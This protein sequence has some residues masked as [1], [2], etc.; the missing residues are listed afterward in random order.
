MIGTFRNQRDR[1]KKPAIDFPSLDFPLMEVD[2]FVQEFVKKYTYIY[3][4]FILI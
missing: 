1:T 2:K 3:I 4:L